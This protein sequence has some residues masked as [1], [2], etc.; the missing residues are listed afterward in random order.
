MSDRKPDHIRVSFDRSRR[1]WTIQ[2]MDAEGNQI[3]AAD[4]APRKPE[5]KA[6]SSRMAAQHR[7]EVRWT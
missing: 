6:M 3:G 2:V 1:I 5:A 4:Y 7:V